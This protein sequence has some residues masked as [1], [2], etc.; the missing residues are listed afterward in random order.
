[1]AGGDD[2]HGTHAATVAASTSPCAASDSGAAAAATGSG[3][4]TPGLTAEQLAPFRSC[5]FLQRA[6]ALAEERK[7]ELS[8]EFPELWSLSESDKIARLQEGFHNFYAPDAVNPY[9]PLAACG[10][11]IVTSE[12]A[13]LHDNG[14]YGMLGLGHS[15][16]EIERV[17]FRS[18]VMANIMTPSF[19]Q[20]RF[21]RALFKEIGHTRPDGRCPYVDFMMLNSG[22]E[23][24]ALATRISDTHAKRQ[25]DTGG[26]H[27]GWHDI[28]TLS[29]E[30]S[31]H[32]RT[33]R[34]GRMSMSSVPTYQRHLA[35]FREHKA[36]SASANDIDSLRAVF[37]HC[38]EHKIHLEIMA[39]EPVMGEGN[40]GYAI[41][42]E[43]YAEAR[44]LTREHGTLL[45]VDSIQAGLRCHGV[46][47]IVD[48]P[49]FQHLDPPDMESFSKAINGGQYPIS[50]LALGAIATRTYVR[51]L[52]GN[53]MTTNPRGCDVGTAVLNA[54][55]PEVRQ[56]IRERGAEFR[57]KLQ[58]LRTDFPDIIT[59]V[60]GTG[61]L[62]SAEVNP[63][64]YA[65]V[66]H[67]GLEEQLRKRGIGV[68][69]GGENSLRFTPHFRITSY[70]ADA[71][72][73]TRLSLA[74]HDACLPSL[75]LCWSGWQCRDRSCHFGHSR[76]HL[77]QGELNHERR[78]GRHCLL[79][80][81]RRIPRA[82]RTTTYLLLL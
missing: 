1:M 19:S 18:Q 74:T 41:T 24:G 15:P 57:A 22:S 55:T 51:G 36:L 44:R 5:A 49:G 9:V 10:P 78:R 82:R 63:A 80:P 31:F 32:G 68:I 25:T 46:L 27:D 59:N 20:L 62:L 37:A 2:G 79:A 12:G 58:Q 11:W 3:R 23:A 6:L 4:L 47:S 7:A 70:V 39:L 8:A 34:V 43:F 48:Y 81:R 53:T 69:H 76:G 75:T 66:G 71:R 26:V 54:V 65:V 52:Y 50:V 28:R 21:S 61:L 40:P 33:Y 35:S 17:L 60:Q 38:D 73:R 16:A 14:G 67:G 29:L 72:T 64:H 42:P 30:G 56:N 77:A 13:I 45:F